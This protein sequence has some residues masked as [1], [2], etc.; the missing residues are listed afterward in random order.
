MDEG[1]LKARAKYLENMETPRTLATELVWSHEIIKNLKQEVGQLKEQ[2]AE[3]ERENE[4]TNQALSRRDKLVE[5]S[6]YD[7]IAAAYAMTGDD[8]YDEYKEMANELR[9]EADGV[10][11]AES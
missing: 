6:V 1:T 4:F 3:L 10:S 2:N 8:L 5:A 11:N 9:R 7:D